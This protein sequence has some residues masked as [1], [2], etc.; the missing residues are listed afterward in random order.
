MDQPQKRCKL[1]AT[2]SIWRRDLLP[3][4]CICEV[5]FQLYQK[6]RTCLTDQASQA[7]ELIS[8]ALMGSFSLEY[9]KREL[10]DCSPRVP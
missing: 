6:G 1:T 4:S 2:L 10:Q 7:N 3:A 8:E 5:F 9:Q